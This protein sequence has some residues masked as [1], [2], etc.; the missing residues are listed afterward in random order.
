MLTIT[1]RGIMAG[2]RGLEPPFLSLTATRITIMLLPNMV[3]TTRLE[4][5]IFR[6]TTG[7]IN[8]NYA[9]PR[10]WNHL[11]LNQNFWCFKPVCKTTYTI[12][13]LVAGHR[14]ELCPT[15]YETVELTVTTNPQYKRRDTNPPGKQ[16]Y[17]SVVLFSGDT[18][19][20]RTIMHN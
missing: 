13:P 15:A 5:A 6:L 8:Q 19:S 9:T 10:W 7:C 3:R 2:K 18:T 20:L 16:Y 14:V 4:L 17:I 12:V 11:E 1:L